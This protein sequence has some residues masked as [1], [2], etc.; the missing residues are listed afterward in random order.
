MQMTDSQQSRLMGLGLVVVGGIIASY[1]TNH[2]MAHAGDPKWLAY[3]GAGIFAVVG[4]QLLIGAKGRLS[5][6]LGGLVCAALSAMGVCVAFSKGAVSGGIPFLPSAWNQRFGH[7]MF[8]LGGLL[9]GAMALYFFVRVIKGDKSSA[10]AVP[11]RSV[12]DDRKKK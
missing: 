8:G 7:V 5:F 11:R 12:H 3:A 2:P 1:A 10:G 6:L 9:T 4:L